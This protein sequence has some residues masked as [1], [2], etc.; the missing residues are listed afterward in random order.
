MEPELQ[1]AIETKLTALEHIKPSSIDTEMPLD[2][3][4]FALEQIATAEPNMPAQIKAVEAA[5][6]QEMY[7]VAAL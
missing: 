1:D 4:R 5:T 6:L 2:M 3:R 7:A